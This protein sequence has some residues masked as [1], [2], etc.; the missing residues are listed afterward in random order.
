MGRQTT[1]N[2]QNRRR[3]QKI[4]KKLHQQSKAKK[5]AKQP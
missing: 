4:K 3:K 5:P 2:L 1:R